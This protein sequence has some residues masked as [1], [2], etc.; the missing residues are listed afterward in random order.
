MATILIIE[1]DEQLREFLRLALEGEGHTVTL[2]QNGA[3]GV[4]R[5][6]QTPTDLILIDIFMPEKEGLEVIMELRRGF[7]TIKII[8]M[9][10]G[11]D[12]THLHFNALDL[13][14]KLGAFR[15]LTKPFDITTLFDAVRETL[16]LSAKEV[17]RE[18]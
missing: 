16:A 6:R 17:K 9:S 13:A 12:R 2:T 10:G 5:Y 8:A 1:D 14:K 18:Q 3:E 7:P 4:T 11:S 15:T